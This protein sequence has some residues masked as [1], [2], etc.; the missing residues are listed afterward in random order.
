MFASDI[1]VG[2]DIVVPPSPWENTD[3]VRYL[4]PKMHLNRSNLV[5]FAGPANDGMTEVEPW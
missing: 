2:Q 3:N 4:N 1:H 5:F